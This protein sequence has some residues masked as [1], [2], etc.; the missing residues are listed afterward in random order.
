MFKAGHLTF[1]LSC[2]LGLT[3]AQ[4][5][6]KTAP[7]TSEGGGTSINV[8]VI[9][10][11]VFLVAI[12]LFVI[13]ALTQQLKRYDSVIRNRVKGQQQAVDTQFTHVP[14]PSDR[15]TESA[16]SVVIDVVSEPNST[17]VLSAPSTPSTPSQTPSTPTLPVTDTE[18][19]KNSYVPQWLKKKFNGFQRPLSK[20]T[21]E[22]EPANFT[23]LASPQ[24]PDTVWWLRKS[25]PLPVPMPKQVAEQATPVKVSA[26]QKGVRFNPIAI[27]IKSKASGRHSLAAE[28]IR[29]STTSFDSNTTV[30]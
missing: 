18:E 22:A 21:E 25:P 17:P 6:T 15:P 13:Y 14:A 24:A 23:T 3:L 28:S 16:S 5:T 12:L 8:I 10:V 11:L 27:V 26:P 19:K 9:I 20:D 30:V 29:S 7:P 1:L 4:D 2:L